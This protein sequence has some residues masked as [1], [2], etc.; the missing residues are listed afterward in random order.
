MPLDVAP[1]SLV[2]FEKPAI[3]RAYE[4]PK[5]AILNNLFRKERAKQG[6]IPGVFP[7]VASSAPAI[8]SS[9]SLLATGNGNSPTIT[10]P[11]TIA[12]GDFCVIFNATYNTSSYNT[13]AGFT[14]IGRQVG[15]SQLRGE[16][17]AKILVGTETTVTGI[18]AAGDDYWIAAVFRGN[19]PISSFTANSVLGQAT[20]AGPTNMVVTSGS[21]ASYP[22]LVFGQLRGY[23]SNVAV[24]LTPA[25]TALAGFTNMHTGRYTIYTSGAVNHNFDMADAGEN[26]IQCGYFTF[27]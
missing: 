17:S 26:L 1:P 10:I 14:M 19:V 3:H 18:N 11:G 13:P 6:Y 23:P 9:I 21:T 16:I 15:V 20:A 8:L 12:A 25:M 24:D 2:G 27:T 22:I 7:S 4:L 5:P